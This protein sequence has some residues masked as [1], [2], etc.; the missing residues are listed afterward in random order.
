MVLRFASRVRRF[1][2]QMSNSS[3]E[4]YSNLSTN[5]SKSREESEEE[6]D[7]AVVTSNCVAYAQEP[8]AEPG[9][10]I[11]NDEL[12]EDGL[13]PLTLEMRSESRI[14]LNEW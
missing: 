11:I 10:E 14:P 8:L 3:S 12:D 2:S 4:L 13:S 6:T 7:Y 5:T 1:F 9:E